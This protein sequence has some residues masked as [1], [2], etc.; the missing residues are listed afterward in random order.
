MATGN[1]TLQLTADPQYLGRVMALWSVTFSG[2]TPIGG[3]IVGVIG[4]DLGPRYALGVGALAC[5]AAGALG[6]VALVRVPPA[7]RYAQRPGELDWRT[8]QQAHES[9]A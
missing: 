2:S 9:R 5:V 3:P 4:D 1:S 8:Y 7:D 6:L